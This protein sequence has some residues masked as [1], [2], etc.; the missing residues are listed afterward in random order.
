MTVNV[1]GMRKAQKRNSIFNWLKQKSVDLILLQETHC[2]YN[3]DVKKWSKAWSHKS[4]SSYWSKGTSRSKGVAILFSDRLVDKGFDISNIDIDSNGR[5]IK[6][7]IDLDGNKIRVTNIYA[8]NDGFERIRFF[9]NLNDI[10]QDGEDAENLIGGDYNCTMDSNLD[11]INCKQ[12]QDKGQIDLH[13]LIDRNDLEDIWRRRNPNRQEF[14]WHGKRKGSRI[15]M[16]L[17]SNYLDSQIDRIYHI[18]APFT[19]HNAV[20]LKLKYN[21]TVRGPGIWKMNSNHLLDKSY[22]AGLKCM[23]EEWRKEKNSFGDIKLWW[24][25]GKRKIKQFSVD[26]AKEL[27]YGRKCHMQTLEDKINLEIHK[28]SDSVEL[29]NM[30]K[31]YDSLIQKRAEGAIIRSRVE[32]W[33]QGE[34]STKYFY[35]LEKRNGKDKAWDKILSKSG[36]LIT[37]QWEIQKRQVEFYSELFTSERKKDSKFTDDIDY[38]LGDETK[39]ISDTSKEKLEE[40]ITEEELKNA[41]KKMKNNKSPG[42]DGITTEFYKLFWPVIGSD[43]HEVCTNGLENKELAYSQYLAVIILLYKKGDRADI[44]NWRPISLLNVDY[45]ITS[46]VLAERLKTVLPEIIHSDQKGCIQGRFIGENIRL[47]DDLIDLIEDQNDDAIFLLL[48]QEKAFDKI[49]WDWLFATLKHFNFGTKFISWLQTMYQNARSC[50]LTNGHQSAYFDITRGIRQG[51]SLSALLYIIQFEPLANKL[52]QTDTTE[53]IEI[54]LSHIHTNKTVKGC[55]YVDDNISMLKNTQFFDNFM[56]I[57]D[58][59]ENASGSRVNKGKTVALTIKEPDIDEINEIKFTNVPQKALGVPVGK[60]QDNNKAFWEKLIDKLTLKLNIWRQRD[61]SF[62]GKTLLIRSIGISQILYAIEMKPINLDNVKRINSILFNFLWSGKKYRIKRDI[63]FLPR[64]MGGLGMT[65]LNCLLKAKRISWITRTLLDA[66]NQNWAA[67]IKNHLCCLDKKFDIKFFALKVTNST[68][69]IKQAAIPIFYKEC[70][71]A[72]QELL[73]KS[74]EDNKYSIAW[75]ND[76]FIL[77]GKPIALSHWSRDGLKSVHDLYHNNTLDNQYIHN[78]ITHKANFIFD[79]YKIRKSFPDSITNYNQDNVWVNM[80]KD[81]ILEIQFSV[82]GIGKKPFKD[83][84]T[85]DIYNTLLLTNPPEIS[86]KTYWIN[87]LNLN[88]VNWDIICDINLCNK[89][90]P[91]KCTDFNWKVIHGLVN[92]EKWLNKMKYSDGKCK[93]CDDDIVEDIEH[94]LYR[95]ENSKKVW[96]IINQIILSFL[97]QPVQ[98]YQVF[99]GAFTDEGTTSMRTYMVNVILSITRYHLW[100]VRNSIKYDNDTINFITSKHRL[101]WDIIQHLKILDSVS[102]QNKTNIPE[103]R[104]LRNLVDIF[105]PAN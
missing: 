89:Y 85:K 57:L 24:D 14:T 101:K 38:F 25:I 5:Y 27:N 15:D 93:V 69:L 68:D 39:R 23:W 21:E 4:K 6:M 3:K 99:L 45:K 84:S 63:V 83:M 88:T 19:D 65:D 2:H 36:E 58:R 73:R 61:L 22:Q 76:R 1:R 100:K 77:N 92:T 81:D 8:P 94:L 42:P 30:K 32:N 49:E 53:G 91:K 33:E 97:G 72:F 44:R 64:E 18:Y 52:R 31:E 47:V 67:I 41:I 11:R 90:I 105:F 87:K 43:L 96:D 103:I 17:T 80:D 20:C 56:H 48:D 75:C 54:H 26:F 29:S 102:E 12:T 59:Y 35:N 7:I 9:A 95:C 71:L 82:P 60:S 28:E 98:L 86:A 50:I 70:I 78:R 40:I 66:S 51:D 34:K 46:K 104:E 79:I 13:H 10:I 37:D 16:W 55:Q 62:I 74:G